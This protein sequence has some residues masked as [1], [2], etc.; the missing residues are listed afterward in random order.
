[1]EKPKLRQDI[2]SA[3]EQYDKAENLIR[4]LIELELNCNET[5]TFENAICQ[6]DYIVQA[7]LLNISAAD[8]RY[9]FSEHEFIRK[10]ARHGDIIELLN[11]E[12][13]KI[14]GESPGFTWD[15][16]A[17]AF[18]AMDNEKKVDFVSTVGSFTAPYSDEFCKIFSCTDTSTAKDYATQL[19]SV[20]E[21]I[22][23]LFVGVSD[24]DSHGFFDISSDIGKKLHVGL[25][26][27]NLLFTKKLNEEIVVENTVN[28]N[29][30]ES[31]SIKRIVA[32]PHTYLGKTVTI[33]ERLVIRSNDVSDKYFFTSP[34][35]GYG[36][37]EYNSDVYVNVYYDETDD[38]ENCI[39]IDADFQRIKVTGEVRTYASS[40]KAYIDATYIE[41]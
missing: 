39:M 34:E 3:S 25:N 33:N 36:R 22:I 41:F 35:K 19:S 20:T 23:K 18:E 28:T 37:Y 6:Y 15:N 26:V 38:I 32:F 30:Y 31:V 14:M 40:G 17:V 4:D 13:K 11:A 16:F 24:N 2:E 9:T 29:L 12:A 27:L 8:G 10:I 21:S 1:M 5:F 7:I